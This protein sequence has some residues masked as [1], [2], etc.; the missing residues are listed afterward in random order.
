MF[1]MISNCS[2]HWETPDEMRFELC[3]KF[4][5]LAVFDDATTGEQRN[6]GLVRWQCWSLHLNILPT[7]T[8]S[9]PSSKLPQY[10][11]QSDWL[12]IKATLQQWIPFVFCGKVPHQTTRGH[13][14]DS[15]VL[16]CQEYLRPVIFDFFQS[17]D[18]PFTFSGEYQFLGR[19]KYELWAGVKTYF[20][21]RPSD[22]E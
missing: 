10:F 4:V 21:G 19:W 12:P 8:P 5:F 15:L 22:S 9:P 14:S 20:Q 2:K 11:Q 1:I 16:L 13:L 17:V 18:S 7:A 6:G 3:G